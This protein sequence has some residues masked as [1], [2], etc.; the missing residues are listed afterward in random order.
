MSSRRSAMFKEEEW[1]RVQ[2]II[3][4]LYLLEDKSLKDVIIILSTLHGFRPSK[5]QLESK[6]KQWHMAKNMT[7][8]EW[9]HVDMRIR[10]RH[11]QGKESK[12]YLSGIPLRPATVE[13]ARSRHSF[14]STLDRV[15]GIG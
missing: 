4:K 2:P 14:E 15:T 6:L 12:V 5:A 13:K 3:R 1:A 11:L 9:K 7:S 8:M 10:K